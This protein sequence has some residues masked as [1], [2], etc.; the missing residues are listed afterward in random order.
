MST[1]VK[2]SHDLDVL[3]VSAFNAPNDYIFLQCDTDEESEIFLEYNDEANTSF[4][5]ISECFVNEMGVQIITK[6]GD[7]VDFQ[8]SKLTD[9]AQARLLAGLKDMFA[10]DPSIL[11]IEI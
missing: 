4:N 3:M 8:F 11:T 2:V 6:T 1:D 9:K 7:N 5:N 10:Q